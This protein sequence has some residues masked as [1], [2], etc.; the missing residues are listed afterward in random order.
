M[1]GLQITEL[2]EKDYEMVNK[3]YHQLHEDHVKGRPDI[4]IDTRELL[5][6]EEFRE[7]VESEEYV[8]AGAKKQGELA[9]FVIAKRKI[10]PENPMLKKNHILYVDAIYVME[11]FR[12]QGVGRSLYAYL[13]ALAEKEKL[14]RINLKV[15]A[16]NTGA[17]AFYESLGFQVQSFN[18]E[19]R[20]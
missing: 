14:Q 10:T 8:A 18:M 16:F 15:W 13:E 20:F 1:E 2:T 17:V 3:A 4:Y 11:K 7:I 12:K 19:K 6:E 5:T 9:G